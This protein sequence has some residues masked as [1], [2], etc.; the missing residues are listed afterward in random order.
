MQFSFNN[1]VTTPVGNY[2]KGNEI[3]DVK[4]DGIELVSG[5]KGDG[6][7]WHAMDITFSNKEGAI[8][9]ERVFAPTE[10]GGKRNTVTYNGSEIQQPSR[11]DQLAVL[12][13]HLGEVLSPKNWE[14]FKVLN[15]NLPNDF[16]KMVQTFIKVMTPAVGKETKLK[17]ITNKDG[18]ARLPY[19]ARVDNDGNARLSNPFIGEHVDFTASE[20][21]RMNTSTKPTP[22]NMD[23][24]VPETA[25]TEDDFDLANLQLD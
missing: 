3:H 15:F 24:V 25:G 14:K 11:F 9:R 22:T 18:Y 21:K 7:E 19:Y 20:L 12:M 5:K 4:F 8:Y 6:T 17:L 10:D 23:T 13:A 2:L 1:V 16:T